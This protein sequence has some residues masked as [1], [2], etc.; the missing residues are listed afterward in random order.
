MKGL[1]IP[2]ILTAIILVAGIFAFIPIDKAI[3]VHD[4]IIAAIQGVDGLDHNDIQDDIE[5]NNDNIESTQTQIAGLVDT[6][7]VSGAI[8]ATPST[9]DLITGGT[10]GAIYL[11]CSDVNS[12]IDGDVVVLVDAAVV[13]EAKEESYAFAGTTLSLQD[14]DN[15][16]ADATATCVATKISAQPNP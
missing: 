6:G 12:G 15:T 14:D 7:S 3:T 11:T 5:T 2:I 1:L 10:A 9:T 8:A 4:Q 16:T 13:S